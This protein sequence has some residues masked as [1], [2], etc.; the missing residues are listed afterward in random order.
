MKHSLTV[1]IELMN[2]S[3]PFVSE[4]ET[5][6]SSVSLTTLQIHIYILQIMPLHYNLKLWFHCI[7][8]C[9][10][11]SESISSSQ[12]V[13]I[14]LVPFPH[15]PPAGTGE[16]FPQAQPCL[17]LESETTLPQQCMCSS[18]TTWWDKNESC[19]PQQCRGLLA[20]FLGNLVS[21]LAARLLQPT[22]R[23]WFSCLQPASDLSH[24][25]HSE[26]FVLLVPPTTLYSLL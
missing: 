23:C 2:H 19:C 3:N 25:L 12:A 7:F 17:N 18:F 8:F 22:C 21:H 14:L 16:D 11:S 4:H 1:E 20:Y 24:A 9:I 26:I 13:F 10:F 15:Q 6:E 5:L